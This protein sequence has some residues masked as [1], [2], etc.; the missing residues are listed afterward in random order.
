MTMINKPEFMEV[1]KEIIFDECVLKHKEYLTETSSFKY[2]H[3]LSSI[4]VAHIIIAIEE[5]YNVDME[6]VQTGLVDSLQDVYTYFVQAIEKKR[7]KARIAVPE[8]SLSPENV[9]Y[10]T[11]SIIMSK[12][13]KVPA[14]KI[15]Q[16][17]KLHADLRLDDV[18]IINMVVE[19]EKRYHLAI[20][21]SRKAEEALTLG[22][23]C[24]ICS[25]TL[26]ERIET[27]KIDTKNV[28]KSA[29]AIIAE[30]HG[31]SLE[32]ISATSRLKKDLGIKDDLAKQELI[33]ELEKVYRVAIADAIVDKKVRTLIEFA[34]LCEKEIKK[35]EPLVN[36]A[37]RNITSLPEKPT[38]VQQIKNFYY[39]Y[40]K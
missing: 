5:K 31:I 9:F 34:M 18:D 23:F 28:I 32:N 21:A 10:T 40:V 12:H 4:D 11:K 14:E 27:P 19:L 17:A 35:Q 25:D 6:F 1:V 37:N 38:L 15:A 30:K 16:Q 22:Q 3:D 7:Q 39:D 20:P 36:Q 26:K 13:S 8:Y 2:D 24:K 29:S 33:M